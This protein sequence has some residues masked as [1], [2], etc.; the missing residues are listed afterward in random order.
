MKGFKQL[1]AK[2][3]LTLLITVFIFSIIGVSITG[4][5]AVKQGSAR[6][7]QLFTINMKQMQ[8]AYKSKVLLHETVE[9]VYSLMLTTEDSENQKL[10]NDLIVKRKELD[11]NFS[12]YEQLSLTATQ[13]NEMNAL[14]DALQQL[15]TADNHIIDLATQNKKQ[16]SYAL[17]QKET[18]P[19]FKNVLSALDKIANDSNQAATEMNELSKT[20]MVKSVWTSIII[21]LI[22]TLLGVNW[23]INS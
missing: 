6:M 1:Q 16:E 13:I 11:E 19:L 10:K 22:A 3:K 9:D 15:R 20:E 2:Q 8:S 12:A 18:V 4:N 23:Y 14:K 7:D 21:T 17:Y 5:L